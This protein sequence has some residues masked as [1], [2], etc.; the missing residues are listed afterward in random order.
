MAHSQRVSYSV[1]AEIL[2]IELDDALIDVAFVENGE[3]GVW[4]QEVADL[5]GGG[6]SLFSEGRSV[7]IERAVNYV[8]PVAVEVVL[9][10][11][12]SLY[13]AG[14]SLQVKAVG[15]PI[16]SSI[17]RSRERQREA[18]AAARL[19]RRQAAGEASRES[20][21]QRQPEI[22]GARVVAR[23]SDLVFDRTAGL[24]ELELDGGTLESTD[25]QGA[26]EIAAQDCEIRLAEAAGALRVSLAGGRLEVVGGQGP[27][28][29][30]LSSAAVL[31]S[32]RAGKAALE[33][34]A[35]LIEATG[36]DRGGV[37]ARPALRPDLSVKGRALEV[38]VDDYRGN[39]TAELSG[40]SLLAARSMVGSLDL[41]ADQET[42]VEV[43]Q[44]SGS[45]T[46]SVQGGS[47]ATIV[48]ATG[49]IKAQVVDSR[50][51]AENLGDVDLEATAAQ[52]SIRSV[53][54]S[55]V[56]RATDSDLELDLQT[57]SG[58]PVV[59]L[60]GTSEARMVVSLPCQ[61]GS[62]GLVLPLSRLEVS[63]CELHAQGFG[64]RRRRGIEGRRQILV[65]ASLSESSFLAVSGVPT[66]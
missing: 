59:Q 43:E 63:G 62:G 58:D 8:G 53:A 56:A 22:P 35:S 51:N 33:G 2:E 52:V 60:D 48:E 16:E 41:K 44:F 28:T 39:L 65:K 25:H 4:V 47:D 10:L 50:L 64:S 1:S 49:S 23:D 21:G 7:R 18:R 29:G 61:V 37:A 9:T 55:L 31:L 15:P 12:Q 27:L 66:Y 5:P 36:G 6:V 57:I 30:T 54:R 40:A 3:G 19:E 46:L 17:E 38:V 45:A 26:M 11:D 14:R 34:E 13:L 20:A 32:T 24:F 42:G